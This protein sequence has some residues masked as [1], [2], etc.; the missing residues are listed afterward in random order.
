MDL[1]WNQHIHPCRRMA[2]LTTD[3]IEY[4]TRSHDEEFGT[5]YRD[6]YFAVYF[7]FPKELFKNIVL[8]R[9]FDIQTLIGN[10][11]GYI[12]LFLGNT[13]LQLPGFVYYLWK[14]L[15]HILSQ[16]IGKDKSGTKMANQTK[17]QYVVKT[18]SKPD[19]GIQDT[20]KNEVEL[21]F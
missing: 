6:K 2:R 8:V 17:I 10:A 19:K 7:Y 18:K 5:E 9:S 16:K 3:F 21:D 11:G 15:K 20:E 4:P 12:G 14:K 13:L 1:E